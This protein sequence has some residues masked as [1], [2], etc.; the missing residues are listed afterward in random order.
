MIAS[1]D[2][3]TLPNRRVAILVFLLLGPCVSARARQITAFRYPLT[4]SESSS[5]PAFK[6]PATLY[7]VKMMPEGNAFVLMSSN[8]RAGVPSAKKRFP[9]PNSTG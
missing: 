3:A 2:M 1:A 6:G 8:E 9:V 4:M 7:V 5:Y